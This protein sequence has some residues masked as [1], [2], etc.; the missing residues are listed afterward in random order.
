VVER[1]KQWVLSHF[2]VALGCSLAPLAPM[3]KVT[4]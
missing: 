3:T 2:I 1:Q 4:A